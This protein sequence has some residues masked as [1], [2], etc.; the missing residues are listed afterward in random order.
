M[1]G[2]FRNATQEEAV[3]ITAKIVDEFERIKS[4]PDVLG[5]DIG[6]IKQ[7]G[8]QALSIFTIGLH[9][10]I[11]RAETPILLVSDRFCIIENT[12]DSDHLYS[13]VPISPKTALLLVKSKY[14]YNK[15]AFVELNIIRTTVSADVMLS[16]STHSCVI[17]TAP[18]Q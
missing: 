5:A 15:Q 1:F 13:D 12:M 18:I 7:K 2:T 16:F 9:I 10:S 14:Y 4:L 8:K 11:I 17:P 6:D 3:S